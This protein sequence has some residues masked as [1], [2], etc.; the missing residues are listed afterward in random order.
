MKLSELAKWFTDMPAWQQT[1]WV[2][3]FILGLLLLVL[4]LN[5]RR[6]HSSSA[7]DTRLARIEANLASLS[8]LLHEMRNGGA[9]AVIVPFVL[10]EPSPAKNFGWRRAVQNTAGDNASPKVAETLFQIVTEPTALVNSVLHDAAR[11]PQIRLNER[12]AKD[13]AAHAV[14]LDVENKTNQTQTFTIP[15]GQVFENAEPNARV[16]NL[17]AAQDVAITVAP[18]TVR[19]VTVPAYCLNQQLAK[20]KGQSGNITPL[21]VRFSFADQHTLWRGVTSVVP[22]I[23]KNK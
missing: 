4:S 12:D 19:T 2:S 21:Q 16:Q 3:W 10:P 14:H 13:D 11:V 6:E 1:L 5:T 7:Q 8:Q 17:V 23:G 22:P 9:A 20:P 15:K 18:G